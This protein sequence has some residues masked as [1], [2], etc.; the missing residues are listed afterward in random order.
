MGIAATNGVTGIGKAAD[1]WSVAVAVFVDSRRYIILRFESRRSLLRYLAR[2]LPFHPLLLRARIK[3]RQITGS[4]PFRNRLMRVRFFWCHRGSS[5]LI[6]PRLAPTIA[7]RN[8]PRQVLFSARNPL[9]M[10]QSSKNR[11]CRK[12]VTV[13]KAIAYGQTV[14]EAKSCVTPKQQWDG[15]TRYARRYL[16]PVPDR[17]DRNLSVFSRADSGHYRT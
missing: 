5:A 17:R 12:S 9:A 6:Q 3:V 11:G 8:L 10:R 2:C 14:E 4:A 7:T 15:F 1:L 13:T 16:E